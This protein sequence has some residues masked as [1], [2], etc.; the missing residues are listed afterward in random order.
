VPSQFE[1]RLDSD[2]PL[3]LCTDW[4]VVNKRG[5]PFTKLVKINSNLLWNLASTNNAWPTP[6]LFELAL[7]I[8]R[9]KM[10]LYPTPRTRTNKDQNKRKRVRSPVSR[11]EVGS[12]LAQAHP[13]QA[14]IGDNQHPFLAIVAFCI[15]DVINRV[16]LELAPSRV[17]LAAKIIIKRTFRQY[18]AG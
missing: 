14:Q 8:E 7:R 11:T 12:S 4:T 1:I 10:Q 13:N 18:I 17:Q 6:R 16:N 2:A 9:P 15:L 3:Y 5:L